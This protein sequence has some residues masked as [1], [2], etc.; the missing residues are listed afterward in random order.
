MIK[1][2]LESGASVNLNNSN[3]GNGCLHILAQLINIENKTEYE[4]IVKTICEGS[5]HNTLNYKNNEGQTPLMIACSHKNI[6]LAEIALKYGADPNIKNS[7]SIFFFFQYFFFLFYFIFNFNYF[8]FKQEME[9]L[10]F[11]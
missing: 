8:F 11:I 6:C 5:N 7:I 3:T 2:L 9:I 10:V 1:V 4:N